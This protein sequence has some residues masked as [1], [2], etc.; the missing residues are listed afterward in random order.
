MVK[1]QVLT[2]RLDDWEYLLKHFP[3]S[4]NAIHK[5]MRQLGDKDMDQSN[6]PG[7]IPEPEPT[8]IPEP[9]SEIVDDKDVGISQ[10]PGTTRHF[11]RRSTV[12]EGAAPVMPPS[13]IRRHSLFAWPTDSKNAAEGAS[14]ERREEPR[15]EIHDHATEAPTKLGFFG[16]VVN[17]AKKLMG[18]GSDSDLLSAA[19]GRDELLLEEDEEATEALLAQFEA[20]TK[21]TEKRAKKSKRK[22]LFEAADDEGTEKHILTLDMIESNTDQTEAIRPLRIRDDQDDELSTATDTRDVLNLGRPRRKT[23]LKGESMDSVDA[24][25]PRKV[26][27]PKAVPR[28][29]TPTT[30]IPSSGVSTSVE[31]I[32]LTSDTVEST[33]IKTDE[34]ITDTQTTREVMDI[35]VDEE[36]K[37]RKSGEDTTDIIPGDDNIDAA[38]YQ[39]TTDAIPDEE[40][41]VTPSSGPETTQDT[42]GRQPTDDDSVKAIS[43]SSKSVSEVELI[44]IFSDTELTEA[45]VD[46]QTSQIAAETS[47]AAQVTIHQAA[48][49]DRSSRSASGNLG[50]TESVTSILGVIA[51]TQTSQV[52]AVTSPAAL[53]TSTDAPG[54]LP[55]APETSDSTGPAHTSSFT[56]HLI[57]FDPTKLDDGDS[58][59]TNLSFGGNIIREEAYIAPKVAPH[60]EPEVEPD[61]ESDEELDR[62]KSLHVMDT[63]EEG[64]RTSASKLNR[65]FVQVRYES[66]EEQEDARSVDSDAEEV[67][68]KE[69]TKVVLAMDSDEPTSGVDKS[70]GDGEEG[71]DEDTTSATTTGTTSA[72]TTPESTQSP[73]KGK[74]YRRDSN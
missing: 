48:D 42:Q 12:D 27:P 18:K 8:N 20:A 3:D 34:E 49:S 38:A 16:K 60:V 68:A 32:Q 74:P 72:S 51:D 28:V 50:R 36:T 4:R 57:V 30:E 14:T 6:W 24:Q 52:A 41:M 40:T 26:I 2:L 31:T 73:K 11:G 53:E 71:D 33:D 67:E 25:A 10:F 13:S 44:H 35:Q 1:S 5:H 23:S 22:D 39:K 64:T 55:A 59:G 62:T 37:G 47:Q 15:G 19:E 43:A 69:D 46:T 56:K 45:T 66:D 61:M 29:D 17:T 21:E 65:R 9:L 54:T 58:A 7:G 63:K 70:V